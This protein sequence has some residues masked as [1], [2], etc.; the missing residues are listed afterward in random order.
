[1]G[2]VVVLMG[3]GGDSAPIAAVPPT[4]TSAPVVIPA[5]TPEPTVNI[6]ATVEAGIQQGLEERPTSVPVPTAS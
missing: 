1:M 4:E 3:S 2:A 5:D 6:D